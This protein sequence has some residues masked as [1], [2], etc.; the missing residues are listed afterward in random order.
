MS[1]YRLAESEGWMRCYEL[2]RFLTI[3]DVKF[4]HVSSFGVVGIASKASVCVE[5][6]NKFSIGF[7]GK[8][9]KKN[10]LIFMRNEDNSLSAKVESVSEDSDGSGFV[11]EIP[12]VNEVV[13]ERSFDE[14]NLKVLWNDG[15]ERK[16][17][18]VL[19]SNGRMVVNSKSVNFESSLKRS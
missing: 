19:E 9:G 4:D 16:P 11:F 8:D 13:F 18:C 3:A 10:F 2:I 15:G 14:A 7:E 5:Y 12:Q 17:S 1:E 6:E